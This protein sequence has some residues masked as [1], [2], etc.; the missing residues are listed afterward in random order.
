M[1]TLSI[2]IS[3]ACSIAAI[4][5]V[6][7]ASKCDNPRKTWQIDQRMIEGICSTAD[8]V[9]SFQTSATSPETHKRCV[10]VI[11]R[12]IISGKAGELKKFSFHQAPAKTFRD[13]AYIHFSH[14]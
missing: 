1:L 12:N 5:T 7:V 4:P 13:S 11:L 6:L 2:L 8:G 14:S 3:D 9:E 10:S